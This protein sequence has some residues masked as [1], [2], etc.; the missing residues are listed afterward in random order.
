[1]NTV[2]N[3]AV[4][5]CC[6]CS[7]ASPVSARMKMFFG[8]LNINTEQTVSEYMNIMIPYH[9]HRHPEHAIGYSCGSSVNSSAIASGNTH[10]SLHR[11]TVIYPEWSL[12]TQDRQLTPLY[13]ALEALMLF[14][15]AS[16][17]W[18]CLSCRLGAFRATKAPPVARGPWAP[19]VHASGCQWVPVGASGLVEAT[20]Q[21]RWAVGKMQS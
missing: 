8:N 4:A 11:D 6:G 3:V 5:R 12:E 19:Q 18:L 1:M 10:H 9:A 7:E 20:R 17:T 14:C 13:A 16:G 15:Y 21:G 2:T